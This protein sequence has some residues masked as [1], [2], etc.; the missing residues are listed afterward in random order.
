[1]AVTI[2]ADIPSQEVYEAVTER[3][4]G[5][6][7]P[8]EIVDGN[9]VHT[10]GEGPNGF[11]VVDVWESRDAFETFFTGRVL[12]AMQ[13]LG[14]Q[15]EGPQPEIIELIHLVVTEEARVS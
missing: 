4:F 9:I 15:M 3:M 10:A 8:T 12:P 13:E 7:R 6:K 1:M 5:T 2:I 14:L 11:R